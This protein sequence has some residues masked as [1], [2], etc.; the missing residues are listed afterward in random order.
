VSLNYLLSHSIV[1]EIERVHSA[2]N[3]L[4]LIR[5]SNCT[6]VSKLVNLEMQY[7]PDVTFQVEHYLYIREQ[8]RTYF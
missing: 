8:V 1:L 2:I 5:G 7:E 4:K 6:K 3:K